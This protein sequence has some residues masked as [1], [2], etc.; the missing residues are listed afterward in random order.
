MTAQELPH[1][2]NNKACRRKIEMREKLAISFFIAIIS[3]SASAISLVAGHERIPVVEKQQRK[4]RG[5]QITSTTDRFQKTTNAFSIDASYKHQNLPGDAQIVTDA[6]NKKKEDLQQK[7]SQ[8]QGRYE[9][10]PLNSDPLHPTSRET[11]TAVV[12]VGPEKTGSSAIQSVLRATNFILETQDNYMYTTNNQYILE[13]FLDWQRHGMSEFTNCFNS[14]PNHAYSNGDDCNEKLYKA[15]LELGKYGSRPSN[16]I[17]SSERFHNEALDL[18]HIHDYFTTNW[19][20]V[21]IVMYYRRYFEWLASLHFQ[22]QRIMT[23]PN[24]K[25][26]VEHVRKEVLSE[27]DVYHKFTIGVLDRYMQH[28]P[29]ASS[30]NPTTPFTQVKVLN[31]HDP[32]TQGDVRQ[33]F[34]CEAI[35]NASHACDYLHNDIMVAEANQKH[36]M[37]QASNTHYP[38]IYESLVYYAQQV[39][40]Y[41]S[42]E[43]LQKNSTYT[44]EYIA[45]EARHY[46]EVELK[47]DEFAFD[48]LDDYDDEASLVGVLTCPTDE[49]YDWLYKQTIVYEQKIVPHY[50]FEQGG[51]EEIDKNFPIAK[52]NF[53]HV[54]AQ[55][56]VGRNQRWQQ[57]FKTIL[58]T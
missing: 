53:C 22:G 41:N 34:M 54:D 16:V 58:S 8:F 56:V 32:L 27:T 24:R 51:R 44:D 39:G 42:T 37:T 4:I 26:I 36:R 47:R 29:N 17:V 55:L 23:V 13:N 38:L 3:V 11:L 1:V 25:S 52:R 9:L 5:R 7:S 48:L 35:P 21:I 28:F 14:D 10:F 2:R 50:H 19:D 12:H 57:Y 30:T 18:S 40:L 20:N 46:N 33:S 15:M 43:L 6:I 49:E 31:V 45:H